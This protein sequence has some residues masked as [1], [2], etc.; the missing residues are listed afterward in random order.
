MKKTKNYAMPYPEQDD[1]FNVED[2][3]DMMVSV[4][5][6]MKKLSDSGAQISSDAEHLYN[7]TKAQMD[8]I[9]KRM[10]AFTALRD[11]STTGDAE[12]KDIRVA[13]DGKEYGNA[14]EAVREQ[15]SDIHKAL[16]GAGASIWSKAKSESK[17]YVAETKGICI[18]NERFMAAGVVTKISRGTFAENE[19]TL[20]LDRECS[21][22]IVEFEKNPGTVYMPSAET[23]KIV[24]T[25]KIIFEAN[26][27]ARC[28]IP[29]EK[30]QYLA[31]DSTATA[32]TSESNHVPY[33]LYDQANKTLECRGF[34]S[35]GSIEPVDPY[36]LALEYKL[37]YDMDDTGLVK[38]ID[39]NRE[40]AASLKEDLDN[41]D[42][43][44]KNQ[45]GYF[46]PFIGENKWDVSQNTNGY[47]V[48]HVDGTLI[49]NESMLV[50]TFI[51]ISDNDTKYISVYGCTENGAWYVNAFRGAFYDENFKYISGFDNN[52]KMTNKE[53]TTITVPENAKFFRT[54]ISNSNIIFGYM[55]IYGETISDYV[56]YLEKYYKIDDI[57]KT[58]DNNKETIKKYIGKIFPKNRINYSAIKTGYLLNY[59]TGAILNTGNSN[60][61]V[62]GKCYCIQGEQLN[63]A[64]L[65]S[66]KTGYTYLQPRYA[67]Y[68]D[69]DVFISGGICSNTSTEPQ[70]LDV[71]NGA[72][73][74]IFGQIGNAS[75]AKDGKIIAGNTVDY[76][77]RLSFIGNYSTYQEV[78]EGIS[79]DN[80]VGIEDKSDWKGKTILSYGDS[81]TAIGNI[82]N[83][84]WQEYLVNYFKF[85]SYY[86]RGIGGQ[87]YQYNKKPWFANPDGS[88]NSRDD[89]GDMT[90][91][92]TYSIP[93]GCT[94]HYGYFSSWDRIT[95][96]IS[97]DIKDDIDLIIVFGVND[98]SSASKFDIPTWVSNATQDALW[99]TATENVL[100]GDYD[101]NTLNGAIAS[102][103][104]KLQARC[105]NALIVFGTGWS[106][107]ANGE[108][109]TGINPLYDE[110]GLNIWKEGKIVKEECN[111]FSINCID[112]W[113]TTGCNPLNRNKYDQDAIHPY[114]IDGK[115]ALAR[116][117]ISG[118]KNIHPIID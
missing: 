57:K 50:S 11:G 85:G 31:V 26:G 33:M 105:P 75:V 78:R 115:K 91:R 110:H 55:L 83:G 42:K 118:L 106:G 113:G 48:S 36:S 70:N 104:M 77:D 117:W 102:T 7:Q 27:N 1:Y 47:Y 6:L 49:K 56:P 80:I 8:N 38:Q 95:T 59:T 35:T 90:D 107:R 19:S 93:N 84:S 10:N 67:F 114:L 16:F 25:T 74:V 97:D 53:F 23:I 68:D 22:Y 58:S 34:G 32:Y 2:F 65:N 37:E 87:T 41:Q 9:Q 73:Y 101:I 20:N 72:E 18:L 88:Y 100:H 99:A 5:D 51:D 98:G 39:A 108:N 64:S 103:I 76:P 109:E 43:L 21:A 29:V 63:I 116:A 46:Y 44:L 28:W 15:T 17:K 52:G 89:N 82:L 12:L 71:P 79:V 61:T 69:R 111:Y 81:I 4:D 112:I 14:G 94:A 24:S 92:S 60:H 62:S 30:G 13:Y 40:A 66:A 54:G 96:M 45:E 3:Q 86:G